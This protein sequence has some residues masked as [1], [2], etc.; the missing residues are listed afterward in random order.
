[1]SGGASVSRGETAPPS[2]SHITWSPRAGEAV[3][4]TVARVYILERVRVT[5]Q[6]YNAGLATSSVT[7]LRDNLKFA[8]RLGAVKR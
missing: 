7:I 3:E 2:P 8:G 5:C 1:M 6:E 4:I